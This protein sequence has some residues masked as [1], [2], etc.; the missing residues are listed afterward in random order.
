MANEEIELA[1]DESSEASAARGGMP[2][3]K[4]AIIAI[5]GVLVLS[6][7]VG[8][9]LYLT[10]G[11]GPAEPVQTQTNPEDAADAE[12][13]S[14]KGE[15]IYLPLDPPITVSL[16][17]DDSRKYLQISM[18]VMSRSDSVIHAI[19]KHRPAIRNNLNFLF[20]GLRFTDLATR[21]GK[22]QVRE[23]ARDEIRKILQENG[24]ASDVE[25]L[26]FTNFVID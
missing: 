26:Y 19:R 7:S 6:G 10:S 9:T 16:D 20:S 15:A 25:A 18:S 12:V 5:A 3:K 17:S 14:P 22:E 11:Q 23:A 4:I 1:D 2:V 24:A 13:D 8:A 21:E